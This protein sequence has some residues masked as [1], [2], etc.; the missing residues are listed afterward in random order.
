MAE[1]NSKANKKPNSKNKMSAAQREAKMKAAEERQKRADEKKA[2]KERTKRIFTWIIVI[3]LVIGLTLP[4][5]GLSAAGCMSQDAAG[6]AS[7]QTVDDAA[8]AEAPA[9][10]SAAAS[11]SSSK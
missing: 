1:N 11:S 2:A 6:T 4:V 7:E 3:I 5:A 9:S 10:A 8:T